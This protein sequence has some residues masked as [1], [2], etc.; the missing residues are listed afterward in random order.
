MKQKKFPS[1]KLIRPDKFDGFCPICRGPLNVTTEKI[2]D[3]ESGAPIETI[4]V[5]SLL[6]CAKCERQYS[7]V[8]IRSRKKGKVRPADIDSFLTFVRE[9]AQKFADFFEPKSEKNVVAVINPEKAT[10][11]FLRSQVI[12]KNIEKLRIAVKKG[13]GL[14]TSLGPEK[15]FVG[16]RRFK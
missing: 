16:K 9:T 13:S 8:D 10:N 1:A 6:V 2:F 3:K 5:I 4:L 14:K 11:Y 7:L 15:S 12:L